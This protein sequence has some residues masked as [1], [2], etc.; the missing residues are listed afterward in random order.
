MYL[1]V[2]DT[3]GNSATVEHPYRHACQSRLWRD[4]TVTLSEIRAGGVDLT[5]VSKLTI[6]LGDGTN[7]GQADEDLD[8]IFIDDIRLYPAR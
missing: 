4:W 1:K 5:Q 7:S 2:E 8:S 6:G 3:A